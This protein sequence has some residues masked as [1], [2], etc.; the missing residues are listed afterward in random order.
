MLKGLLLQRKKI[1]CRRRAVLK[2]YKDTVDFSE[3]LNKLFLSSWRVSQL[4]GYIKGVLNLNL[5][6]ISYFY[7]I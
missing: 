2:E 6:P 7:V 5:I 3:T 1:L 4:A